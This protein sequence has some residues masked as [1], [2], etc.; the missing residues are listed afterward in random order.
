[1]QGSV[2]MVMLWPE[3]AELA[4]VAHKGRADP[5]MGYYKA[6][7]RRLGLA[8]AETIRVPL[9]ELSPAA[10]RRLQYCTSWASRGDGTAQRTA[11]VMT[12]LRRPT[13]VER[14]TSSVGTRAEVVTKK[15]K[16]RRWRKSGGSG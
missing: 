10:W 2:R 1:M 13:R 8:P 9:P 5:W 16:V 14:A 7:Q 12:T 15:G 3:R 6:D 4:G 11:A